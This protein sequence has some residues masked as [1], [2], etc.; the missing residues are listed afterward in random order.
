MSKSSIDYLAEDPVISNQKYVCVS[1]LKPS[2][3]DD[4]NKEKVKNITVT[5]FKVR[6]SYE[7][8]EEAKTRADFLTKCDSSFNIYIAEVGKWCPYEDDPEKASDAEYQNKDLNKLMKSYFKQQTE[9]KEYHEIRKQEMVNK[10]LEETK[11]KKMENELNKTDSESDDDDKKNT[12]INKESTV[13]ATSKKKSKNNSIK[14]EKMKEQLTKS[15]EEL[16][17][18]KKEVDENINKLRKLEDELEQKMKELE[19]EKK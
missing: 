15:Q 19:L 2:S 17:N 3:I 6:G 11:K 13:S 9:A 18:D 8:Y 16:D 5:G 14:L 4:N 10:A 12:T 7:T 1:F